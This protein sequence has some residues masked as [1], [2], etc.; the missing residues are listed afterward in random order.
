MLAS[1]GTSRSLVATVDSLAWVEDT[2]AMMRVM[3]VPLAGGTPTEVVQLR[4]GVTHLRTNGTQLAWNEGPTIFVDGRAITTTATFFDQTRFA[5]DAATLYTPVDSDSADAITI[6]D[7][8]VKRSWAVHFFDIITD[9]AGP[10]VANCSGPLLLDPDGGPPVRLALDDLCSVQIAKNSTH[11]FVSAYSGSCSAGALVRVDRASRDSIAV[12]LEDMLGTIAADDAFLY[13]LTPEGLWR[14][15]VDGGT[16]AL[17]FAGNIDSFT[18]DAANVY[19]IA[20]GALS[21]ITK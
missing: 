19:F 5:F 4:K 9:D 2:G 16:P 18:T 20:N 6:A 21:R 14:V 11:I 13:Y 17:L 7:G 12:V 8:T 10:L 3:Q 1:A 15:A